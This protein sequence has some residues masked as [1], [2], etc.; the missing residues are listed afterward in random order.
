MRWRGRLR[1]RVRAG[2][3]QPHF[4]LLRQ[5]REGDIRWITGLNFYHAKVRAA[6]LQQIEHVPVLGNHA[7]E[8][9][10]L[11]APLKV[12]HQPVV[13]IRLV[14]IGKYDG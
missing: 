2:D 7:F 11:I 5:P 12:Q 9:N 8:F 13:V 1:Q 3:E 10:I 4:S 6:A 14:G